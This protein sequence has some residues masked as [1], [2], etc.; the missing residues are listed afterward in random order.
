[1]LKPNPVEGT[2]YIPV[3]YKFRKEKLVRMRNLEGNIVYVGFGIG[4][5]IEVMEPKVQYL[6]PTH[7]RILD[8]ELSNGERILGDSEELDLERQ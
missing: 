3:K 5:M 6:T 4:D 7:E 1:M 2:D 8:L